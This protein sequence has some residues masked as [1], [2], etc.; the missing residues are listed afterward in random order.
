M[1][2][3]KCGGEMRYKKEGHSISWICDI[4]GDAVA[5]S[6]FEPYETDTTD[7][8]ILISASNKTDIGTLKIVAG[9]AN[10]NYIEAKKL[11]EKAPVEVFHGQAVEVKAIKEKFEATS[12][13]F[14][15]EPEFPY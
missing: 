13:D 14:K 3:D 6:F 9:V 10:C 7:Y 2:C 8:H 12:I 1:I 5:S 15:I 4:C 11:I